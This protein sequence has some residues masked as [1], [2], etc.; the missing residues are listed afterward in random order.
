MRR[1]GPLRENLMQSEGEGSEFGFRDRVGPRPGPQRLGEDTEGG[2]RAGQRDA[3]RQQGES[4]VGRLLANLAQQP[5][6][7]RPRFSEDEQ[8]AALPVAGVV[9]GLLD[10]LE[11]VIAPDDH[12]G[13]Q[14]DGSLAV[15]PVR[16]QEGCWPGVTGGDMSEANKAIIR[17]WQEAYT[18]GK[19]HELDDLVA[20]DWVTNGWPEG[21]P[22]SIEMAKETHRGLQSAVPDL[23]VTTDELIAEGDRI[24][25]RWT[26]TARHQIELFGCQ[27]TG[28]RFQGGGSAASASATA[29]SPSTSCMPRNKDEDLVLGADHEG[30]GDR[31]A[32]G[33]DPA[34]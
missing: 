19:L 12:R 3:S 15:C 34:R 21:V 25:Q 2:R 27:P 7:A 29:R 14:H 22:Q 20:P 32:G 11:L 8:A 4:A 23:H 5:G 9:D 10:R 24:G 17:R 1:Q 28:K 18:D 33:G 6:L 26:V 16:R 31:A 30:G 13:A